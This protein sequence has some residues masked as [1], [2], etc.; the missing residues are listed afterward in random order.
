MLRPRR[1]IDEGLI[2]PRDPGR[3]NNRQDRFN[4]SEG[5]REPK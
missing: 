3:G 2:L 1:P 4:E 5:F